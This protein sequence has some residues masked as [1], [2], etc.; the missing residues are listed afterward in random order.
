MSARF[1]ILFAV[2]L[3]NEYYTQL[4]CFD[5]KI[6]PSA[7]TIQLMKDSKMMYKV[8]NN[9]LLVLTKV[10]DSGADQ[11]QPIVP[12]APNKKFVFYLDLVHPVFMN[13]T[14]LDLDL[15][16]TKR[17][18]FS[19]AYQ[20][21][22]NDVLYLSDAT[23]D[24]EA[25]AGYL[26]GMLA[27][28]G[29]N[30]FECIRNTPDSSSVHHDTSETS[31]W[32]SRGKFQYPSSN[33]LIRIVGK[34]CNFRVSPAASVFNVSAFKLNTTTNLTYDVEV[35]LT[36]KQPLCFYDTDDSTVKDVQVDLSE[37][38]PGRYRIMINSQSFDVYIDDYATQYFG[39]MEFF[40]H[41]GGTNEFA[42]LDASG[43]IKDTVVAGSTKWLNYVIRFANRFAF[44]K[45]VSTKKGISS[46][47]ADGGEYSFATV[48]VPPPPLPSVPADVFIS[49]KPIPMYD[50]QSI[51]KLVLTTPITSDP[52]KAPNPNPLIPGVLT[53]YQSDFYCTIYLNY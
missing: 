21:K 23:K 39:V 33:D 11:D 28:D 19:N 44:R 9:Q 6:I 17:F 43:K 53:R 16:A 42:L 5:F 12:V 52:I 32:K 41:L 45:F 51:F 3:L 48:S 47:I 40:N 30:I 24:Y 4:R 46:I 34:I 29:T 36:K 50:K 15:L 35:P 14:N 1:K 31:F 26:P 37:L 38:P 7:E 20:N 18:Y 13:I 27:S 49:D 22:M 25:A 10:F 8:I 2:E